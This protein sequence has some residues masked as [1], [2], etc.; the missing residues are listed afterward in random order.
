M[1]YQRR[2]CIYIFLRQI[3]LLASP[4]KGLCDFNSLNFCTCC[5]SFISNLIPSFRP[6]VSTSSLIILPFD[7]TGK[8]KASARGHG[9]TFQLEIREQKNPTATHK[10]RTKR[11]FFICTRRPAVPSVVVINGD[12][13]F[14]K[15][16]RHRRRRRCSRASRVS[17]PLCSFETK[18]NLF[19][20]S[21]S[22]LP[23]A[24][25]NVCF[26]LPPNRSVN[27][28]ETGQSSSSSSSSSAPSSDRTVSEV[29]GHI[30]PKIT[31]DCNQTSSSTSCFDKLLI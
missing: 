6:T 11:P 21:S 2:F 30:H 8:I 12:L 17:T 3:F 16:R 15:K 26:L 31:S 5:C 28:L 18:L 7:P 10:S 23:S 13:C 29:R 20:F 9:R 19:S 1:T 22:F 27:F 4:S 14:E 24:V 25:S